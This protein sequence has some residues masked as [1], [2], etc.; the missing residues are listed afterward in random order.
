M[1]NIIGGISLTSSGVAIVNEVLAVDVVD[2]AGD[3]VWA[4]K[5]GSRY[6]VDRRALGVADFTTLSLVRP[7]EETVRR[8]GKE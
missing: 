3:G 6:T 4:I 7:L 2:G 1:N 5:L 8:V